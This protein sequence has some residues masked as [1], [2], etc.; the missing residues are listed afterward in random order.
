MNLSEQNIVKAIV[1]EAENIKNLLKC[2]VCLEMF[3]NP[4]I[5]K[6]GHSF[7][8]LCL[9]NWILE[10]GTKGRVA[11]PSCKHTGVTKRSLEPSVL[12]QQCLSKI[13]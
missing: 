13:K 8:K 7:C 6:C 4:V 9:E 11:C 12:L 3:I 2:P 5:T 1:E 10:K